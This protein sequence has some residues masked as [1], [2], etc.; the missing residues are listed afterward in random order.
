MYVFELFM[1]ELRTFASNTT[2]MKKYIAYFVGVLVLCSIGIRT[3]NHLHAWLGI[4]I[5]LCG[6]YPLYK[7]IKLFKE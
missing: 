2:N 6:L 5:C 1:Y 4:A 7:L 3:F